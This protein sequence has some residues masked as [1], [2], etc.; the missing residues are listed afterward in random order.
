MATIKFKG[1]RDSLEI[2][3]QEAEIIKNVF[4][5][6]SISDDHIIKAGLLSFRKRE[7][8]FVILDSEQKFDYSDK[9]KDNLRE[10][11]DERRKFLEK[12]P[13]EKAKITIPRFLMYWFYLTGELEVPQ[14]I[15]EKFIKIAEWFFERR[16]GRRFVDLLILKKKFGH[17]QNMNKVNWWRDGAFRILENCER[18]DR[19][20]EEND[21]KYLESLKPSIGT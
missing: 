14:N 12:T 4:E 18:T 1:E 13:Q 17:L 6:D 20:D 21:K 19:N 15:Q 8:R 9:V 5:D 16:K 3:P 10:Y 11:H 2:H 7:I